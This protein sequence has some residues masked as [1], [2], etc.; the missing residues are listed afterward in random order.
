M[1]AALQQ[2]LERSELAKLPKATVSKLEKLLSDKE[3]EADGLKVKYERFKVDSEQQYFE[4][5]KRLTQSQE[6][7]VLESQECQNL[8]EELTKLNDQLT[9]TKEK[10]K[11]LDSSQ[12]NLKNSQN[13]LSRAKDEL[14]N[15]KRELVRTLERRSQELEHLN[16]DF[17]RLNTKLAETNSAKIDLQLKLDELQVSEISIKYREKRLEQEKELLQNQTNWLN[18]ELKKKTDEL[19]GLRREKSNEILELRCNLENKK[20]EV[21]SIEEQISTL[22]G[23]NENFKKQIDDL[24]SKLKESKEH[25]ASMEEKF[26]NE[27]NAHIKLSNLY[28]SAAD[29]SEA[30]AAELTGA[31][32]ELH[33]LLKQANEAHKQS[34]ERVAETVASNAK[35]ITDL[36]EKVGKLEKELENANDLLV[37]TKRKGIATLSEEE[38]AAMSP[39]AAAVAK[40]IK[41]GMKLTELYN[42]YV[43]AQDQLLLAKQENKRVNKYLDEIV[44]EVEMK[45]PILKRQREEYERGQKAVA[46]L[47]AKLEEAMKEMRR[48]QKDTDEANKSSTLLGRENQRLKMQMTDLSQQTR[49][50][51][52]ELEDSRGNHVLREDEVS[53]ADI[54]SSSEVISQHLVT[55]RSIEELQQQNQQLLLTLRELAE[56]HEKEEE[57]KASSRIKGLES[58]LSKSLVELEGLREARNHQMQMVESIVRQR[59]MYRILLAHT[60]GVSIPIQD[61]APGEMSLISSLPKHSPG[62]SKE[63]PQMA[64]TPSQIPALETTELVQAKAALKQLQLHFETYKKEKAENDKMLNEQNDKL[65]DGLTQLRTQNT[66]LSTQLEFASKRYEMLQ[67]NIDAFRREIS[68]LRDRGQKLTTTVQKQEHII[69]SLTQELRGSN[70]KLAIE[71]ARGENLRKEKDMLKMVEARLTQERDSKL[72]EHRGQSLLLTNL[73]SIQLSLERA[74]TETRQRLNNQIERQER[75]ITQLKKKLENEV[76]QRHFLG[77]NQ[78]VQLVEIKKQYETELGLHVKTKDLLKN[79]EKEASTLKQQLSNAETQLVSH[80]QGGGSKGDSNGEEDVDNLRS[81]LRQAEEQTN[82]LRERLKTTTSN[83]EQYRGM[84]LSLEDS[85]S[86]EKQVTEEVRAAVE[87]RLTESAEYQ[88][89][90][91]KRLMEAEKEKQDLTDEKRKTIENLEQQMSDLRKN[92]SSLQAELQEALQRA[93]GAANNEQQARADCQEQARIASEAQNKY[94]RELI[95]H[96]A[97]V[98][99]LQTAKEQVAKTSQLRQQLEDTAQKAE[100]QLLEMKTA[101]EELEQMLKAEIVKQTAH[102]E[103]LQKQNKLLLEQVEGLSNKMVTTVQDASQSC[104]NISFSEE[105]KSQEQL[106]EILRF[107][108]RERE[109]ADTKFEVAQVEC[110]RYRQRMENLEREMKEVQNNLNSEREKVQVTAKTLAQHDELMKKTE[111]MNVLI[112]TNKMLRDERERLEQELQQ[113]HSKI[114]KLESDILPLQ[115]SNTELSEK[116]GMLQAEKKLLEEDLK[117]WK[118]RAQQLI[119]QQKETDPDEYKKLLSEKDVN[120]KRI[121]QLTEETGK[122]KTDIARLNAS[123][124]TS[125]RDVQTLRIEVTRV[126]TERDNLKQEMV[127]KVAENLEKIKTI[128]QVK[129][130]G[131]RYKTQYE[132]LKVQYDKMVVEKSSQRTAEQQ[133]EQSS[134][135]ATQELQ[136]ILS[137]SES[138]TK[139]L[140]SQTEALQKSINEKESEVKTLQV[141][142]SQQQGE[143]SRLRQELQEKSTLEDQ[144]RQQITEKEEKMKKA[145]VGAKQKISQLVGVKDQMGKE[146]EELKQRNEEFKQR[147]AT[148]DQQREELEVRMSALKSQ[149]DGHIARLKRELKE[150]QDRQHEQREEPQELASKASEPQRQ[151]DQQRQITLKQTPAS[152]DRG[153]SSASE[154]PT[155]NIKPTPLV[156]TPS[157]VPA[158]TVPGSKST[159]RASIRPMVTPATVTAPAT[160]PTATVMPTTQVESQ[161]ATIQPE[162][163]VE[164]VTVFGSASGTVR[165][166]SPNIPNLSQ[167]ILTVQQQQTQ[168]T[169]FVQPTQQTLQQVE[170]ANQE[171]SATI[172]ELV[173][174]SQI[175]RPSTSTAVFGTVS[176]TTSISKRQRDEEEETSVENTDHAQEESV[177]Q[178]QSKKLRIVQRVGPEEE[179]VQD[180]EGNAEVVTEMQLQ[181]DHL[182]SQDSITQVVIEEDYPPSQLMEDSQEASQTLPLELVPQPPEHQQSTQSSQDSQPPDVIIIDSDEEDEA[183]NEEDQEQEYDE[184]EEDDEDEDDDT[185]IEDGDGEDSNEGSPGAEDNYDGDDAEGAEGTDPSTDNEQSMSS[186]KEGESIQRPEDIQDNSGGGEGGMSTV[187]P[188]GSDAPREHQSVA[189]RQTPRPPRSPRRPPHHLPPRLTIQP[190]AQE[191]GPPAQRFP[192]ARRPSSSRG[193]IQLTPGIAGVQQHFFDEDDRMVPS[194]P[195]LFVPHRSDGFAEVIHSPQVTAVPSFGFGLS[196]DLSQTSSSQSDLGQLASQG[197]L[198]MYETPICLAAVHEDESGG[199]SV[200]TTPLQVHAPVTVFNEGIQSDG[201]EHASQSVPM[202]TTTL[203]SLSNTVESGGGGDDGDEVFV[204]GGEQEGLGSDALLE[205]EGQQ[206]EEAVQP[207]EEADLPSTSQDPPSSSADASST[208]PKPLRRVR[209]HPQMGRTVGRGRQFQNRRGMSHAMGGRGGL[210]RGNLG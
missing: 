156:A 188:F 101:K 63:M 189:E 39:T 184:E 165:S 79:A 26:R 205:I 180:I 144:L 201:T 204:E 182:G 14:D 192:P 155:A 9:E 186:A 44:K 185:G 163:P 115:E 147:I 143:L 80:T 19:L 181:T 3:A 138:R 132:E 22:K 68:S 154:P 173:Q 54:S 153:S 72:A 206:E 150:H 120:A 8:R 142:V 69:C 23:A 203:T 187:E 199:R 16:E 124:T 4:V 84:V 164:H 89:Q 36:N 117:R 168:A 86:K 118:A 146:N 24:M 162:G 31:V 71:E 91:E 34:E 119:S 129:K 107:V 61:K 21:S 197:G 139:A 55:Y 145:I 110:L 210:N 170:P 88:A 45:A 148:M 81:R 172:V 11:E 62:L 196:E 208:Q 105:G 194:T 103:D 121:Q 1:A 27:L 127:T 74:E 176:A 12:E 83:L 60:T 41:P 134:A 94:E 98:E 76:E 102:C 200:P 141:E 179:H 57:E 73:Q 25:S 174:T 75:E 17:K 46:N 136:E 33:S 15:E 42:A 167:P 92:L 29:D 190:P 159:P 130:I 125:Q 158:G 135:Q 195:T 78:D 30:K 13:Q 171:P 193:G 28:K 6:K 7:L 149:Y 137:Q 112:E 133:A 38:L 191:L 50:L 122:L 106:L 209:L 100:A 53:S 198:G 47:S 126:T 114:R 109:I 128:T 175:E 2:L 48:L 111:T 116:S 93:T 113:S 49:I 5:E 59:D 10:N 65:Q 157:K 37:A 40:V 131:R 58:D 43:E 123:S 97:D 140:E 32:E 207:S 161:E 166:T 104:M 169:A 152:T 18:A 90:L 178:P 183:E 160:T 77:R 52:M 82:D 202:V 151:L 66:K 85:I 51:L 87:S 67:N 95:L 70:E 96:A 99:A 177:D 64:S 20:D 35:L 108:R 56:K